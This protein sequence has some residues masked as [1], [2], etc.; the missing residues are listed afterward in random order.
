MKQRQFGA[1][2]ESASL[3]FKRYIWL[4][5]TIYRLGGATYEQINNLWVRSSINDEGSDFALRTFH[6]H[7][8]SIEDIFDINIE[9]D[10]RNG[11][12]YYIADADDMARGGV[13]KWLL[14]TFAVN[15]LIN[16]SHKL[17]SRILFEHIPSG[18]RFLTSIIEAMRTSNTIEITYQSFNRSEPSIFEVKPY[19]VKVYRLRW[20]VV[21]KSGDKLRTYAL[22]RILDL[23]TTDN[24]FEIDPKF[25]AEEHFANSVGVSI[26]KKVEEVV[27]KVSREENKSE[28]FKE[29]PL[30]PSQEILEEDEDYTTFR[31][32][33]HHT[34][35]LYQEL[36]THAYDI[37]VIEPKKLRDEMIMVAQAMIE[38]YTKTE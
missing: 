16:E 1:D 12:K 17:K 22:D 13:R 15:N 25:D 30:H 34:Y 36:T 11:Y 28:Y 21:A 38:K 3:L 9:C 20:Y 18:Q 23:F 4:V 33:L 8:K 37:E 5:D 6:N 26:G 24:K 19:C 31:Y 32:Q 27:I 14:N 29:L 35:D 7:R 2:R 10:K